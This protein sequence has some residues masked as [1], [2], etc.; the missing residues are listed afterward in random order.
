MDLFS[1]A[2]ILLRILV[3]LSAAFLYRRHEGLLRDAH[4]GDSHKY[5]QDH[6]CPDRPYCR[7]EDHNEDAADHASAETALSGRLI[8]I[9]DRL[10]LLVSAPEHELRET[11]EHDQKYLHCDHLI[12]R[13]DIS[14]I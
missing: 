13:A 6:I 12:D 1:S 9:E 8:D 10:S 4:Q 11:A 3:R 7:V 14:L 5:E 2:V